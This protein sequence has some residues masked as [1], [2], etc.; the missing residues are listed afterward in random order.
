MNYEIALDLPKTNFDFYAGG[1]FLKPNTSFDKKEVPSIFPIFEEAGYTVARGYN[2]YKAKAGK[3]DKMIL[4][5]EEGANPWFYQPQ[6]IPEYDERYWHF[7]C[8]TGDT[9]VKQNLRRQMHEAEK[10]LRGN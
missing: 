7:F 10:N 2:D 6:Q 3:A 9:S 4:I 5:Q 8:R 1:G